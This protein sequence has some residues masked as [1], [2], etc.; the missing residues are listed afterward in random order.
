MGMFI[1]KFCMEINYSRKV[2]ILLV[3]YIEAGLKCLL[4]DLQGLDRNV[5]LACFG[6]PLPASL[7][8]G[9]LLCV[10]LLIGGLG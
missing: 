7:L 4:S 3:N 5:I 9:C 10:G 1:L 6:Q 8:A 2:S